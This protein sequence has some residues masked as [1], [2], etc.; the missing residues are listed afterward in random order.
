MSQDDWPKSKL[1]KSDTISTEQLRIHVHYKIKVS[2][3]TFGV[4]CLVG[5]MCNGN[6]HGYYELVNIW[7]DV[8]I[9]KLNATQLKKLST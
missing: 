8:K 6:W 1:I 5:K 4:K 9:R 2:L 7:K 3:Y